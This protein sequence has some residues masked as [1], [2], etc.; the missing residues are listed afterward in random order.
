MPRLNNKGFTFIE[1]L[2][3][4]GVIGLLVVTVI[5]LLDPIDKFQRARVARMWL[6]AD[7]VANAIKVSQIDNEG[8]F[9]RPLNVARAG[10]TY[11]ISYA[12]SLP[13]SLDCNAACPAVKTN[14]DCLNFYSTP[15]ITDQYL[16]YMPIAPREEHDW[17]PQYTGYYIAKSETGVITI[18]SCERPEVQVSK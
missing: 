7:A 8:N 17:T 12:V 3:V 10:R 2:I 11:M 9:F 1:L 16:K 14:F 15:V 4:I 13:S 5:Q 18:G 6:E